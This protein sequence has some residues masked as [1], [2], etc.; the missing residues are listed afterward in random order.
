MKERE[1][2]TQSTVTVVEQDTLTAEQERVL[3]MRHGAPW[4]N[5]RPLGDKLDGL[6]AAHFDEVA[7]KLALI[8]AIAREQ[9]SEEAA[10]D[11]AVEHDAR[12]TRIIDALRGLDD[13]E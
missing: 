5:T 3:R 8:E 11:R 1:K 6:N 10:I 12:K 9:I 4:D 2:A 13:D 7:A